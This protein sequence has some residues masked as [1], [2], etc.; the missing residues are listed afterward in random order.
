M[1]GNLGYGGTSRAHLLRL[2]N[3]C[4]AEA[5]LGAGD[6]CLAQDHSDRVI[7][8][9]ILLSEVAHGDTLLSVRTD[10]PCTGAIIDTVADPVAG[11][12]RT[13]I[14]GRLVSHGQAP[15]KQGSEVALVGVA[16]Y[17]VYHRRR[18]RRPRADAFDVILVTVVRLSRFRL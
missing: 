8:H 13:T 11:R 18:P 5:R 16:S 7:A 15:I 10:Y 9:A 2:A 14:D 1:P 6:S 3:R 17:E 12:T 4:A